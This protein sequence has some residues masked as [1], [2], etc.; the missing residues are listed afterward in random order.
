MIRTQLTVGD[1]ALYLAN[2]GR[3][4]AAEVAEARA[5]LALPQLDGMPDLINLFIADPRVRRWLQSVA[6]AHRAL[7]RLGET[8][9]MLSYHTEPRDRSVIL[10]A[11]FA[12]AD[13]TLRSTHRSGVQIDVNTPRWPFETGDRNDFIDPVTRRRADEERMQIQ[14]FQVE[15]FATMDNHMIQRVRVGMDLA[16]PQSDDIGVAIAMAMQASAGSGASVEAAPQ[17]AQESKDNAA[18]PGPAKGPAK[19]KLWRGRR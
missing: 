18:S 14:R 2:S 16:T 11:V 8:E 4:S 1:E 15:E 12:P 6:D 13:E 17:P 9:L 19:R 7:R 5:R 10:G 3:W